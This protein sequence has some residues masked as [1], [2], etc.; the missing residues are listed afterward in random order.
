[1]AT[2]E[3]PLGGTLL[4]GL[5]L[6]AVIL[7]IG[8]LRDW[9]RSPG[10]GEDR[11]ASLVGA[12][13]SPVVWTVGFVGFALL[14]MVGAIAFVGGSTVLGIGPGIGELILLGGVGAVMVGFLFTGLYAAAKNRGLKSA[15]AAGIGSIVLGFL[16]IVVISLQLLTL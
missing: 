1:M 9:E 14:F 15:Q 5:V 3:S 16:V 11:A 4:M 8:V 13:R 7:A 12:L 10:S 6:L 2:I